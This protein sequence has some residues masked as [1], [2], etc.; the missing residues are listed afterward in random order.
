MV[1]VSSVPS[2]WKGSPNRER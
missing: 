2:C 1:A